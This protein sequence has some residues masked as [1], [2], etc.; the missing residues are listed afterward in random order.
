MTSQNNGQRGHGQNGSK[1]EGCGCGGQTLFTCKGKLQLNGRVVHGVCENCREHTIRSLA[2]QLGLRIPFRSGQVVGKE[3]LA[4][5]MANTAREYLQQGNGENL[6]NIQILHLLVFEENMDMAEV[7]RDV[8]D[9]P[10]TYLDIAI[11]IQ[12]AARIFEKAV[13]FARKQTAVPA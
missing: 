10:V 1:I 9:T 2:D 12:A 13:R 3:Q 6:A 5:L 7:R 8:P 11:R 4:E